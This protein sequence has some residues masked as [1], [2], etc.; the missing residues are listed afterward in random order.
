[1]GYKFGF[2]DEVIVRERSP[3][4]IYNVDT[5]VDQSR[6]NKRD[7]SRIMGFGKRS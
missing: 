4:P 7:D 3:G 6:L 1:M 5:V 2:R